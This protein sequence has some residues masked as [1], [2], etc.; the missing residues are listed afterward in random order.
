LSCGRAGYRVF[1]LRLHQP[2]LRRTRRCYQDAFNR[3]VAVPG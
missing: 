2:S 3:G 1:L